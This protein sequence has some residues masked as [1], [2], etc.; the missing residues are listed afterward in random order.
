[1]P[2]AAYYKQV[3][4]IDSVTWTPVIPN[5]PSSIAGLNYLG[6]KNSSAFPILIRT[7]A[8]DP[9]TEDTIYPG[10]IE[11]VASSPWANDGTVRF[12]S[13]AATC[14]LQTTSGIA[15]AIITGLL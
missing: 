15:N 6:I 8:T 2:V 14:Y 9:S 12:L 1:M 5:V 4:A 10:A 3:L 13:G 7:N 11:V